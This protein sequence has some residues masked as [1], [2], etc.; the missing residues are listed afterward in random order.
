MRMAA[1]LQHWHIVYQYNEEES[2]SRVYG[3]STAIVWTKQRLAS[4]GLD[5]MLVLGGGGGA[6]AR[7]GGQYWNNK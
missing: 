1:I 2:S 6:L 7:D 3:Q 5:D 4:M